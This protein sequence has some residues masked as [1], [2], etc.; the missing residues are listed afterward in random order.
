[1]SFLGVLL[2]IVG[3]LGLAKVFRHFDMVS[4]SRRNQMLRMPERNGQGM[5]FEEFVCDTDLV[6]GWRFEVARHPKT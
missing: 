5:L 1:M 2:V 6:V 3:V 4:R